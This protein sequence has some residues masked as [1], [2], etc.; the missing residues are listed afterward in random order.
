MTGLDHE[1]LRIVVGLAVLL[2]VGTVYRWIAHRRRPGDVTRERWRALGTWWVLSAL[3]VVVLILGRP[4]VVGVCVVFSLLLVQET[5]RLVW[6]ETPVALLAGSVALTAV[7]YLWAVWSWESLFLY[8]LPV[9]GVLLVAG[10]ILRRSAPGSA[11]WTRVR[12]TCIALSISVFG[13]SF[14]VAVAS[15]PAPESLPGANLGWLVLLLALTEL[16][17]SAQAWWGR[18]VGSHRMAPRL[19]PKKT[20]EGL[21]GGLATVTLAA[22]IVAPWVTSYGRESP[23]GEAPARLYAAGLGL[24]VGLAATA[25]D[26]AASR[27]KRRAGVKDS[28]RLLPG[29]GGVLD[30]FDSLT[31][32][33]PVY[34]FVTHF[35]WGLGS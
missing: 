4:A 15:L 5:L 19:S 3:L 9:L 28:G 29:H 31:V 6:R 12:E 18:S 1:T 20:W 34:F 11:G 17:D 22:V 2:V 14:L 10:E 13:P 32:A 30:R 16:N 8:V 35:L 7:V 21:L 26:L 23:F 24:L 33:A 25:G 27:L